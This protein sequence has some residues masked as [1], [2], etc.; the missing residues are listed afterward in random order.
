MSRPY[1]VARRP[2]QKNYERLRVALQLYSN[3]EYQKALKVC[4][5]IYKE[6]ATDTD[7]LILIGA[8]Y[9]QLYQLD[10]CEFYCGQCLSV[11]PMCAE[12]MNNLGA[13]YWN[14]FEYEKSRDCFEKAT[15]LKP[16]FALSYSNLGVAHAKLGFPDKALDSLSI[17]LTL[18][19]KCVDSL[20]NLGYFHLSN[21]NTND[22][23]KNYLKALQYDPTYAIP[24]SN[25]GS[26]Y[27]KQK[28]FEKS[29][30]SL[31]RALTFTKQRLSDASIN[32]SNCG[33]YISLPNAQIEE[34]IDLYRSEIR[35]SL[36]NPIA[37]GNFGIVSSLH[38]GH[39]S[40][41]RS[42]LRRSV[43]MKTT[44]SENFYN[45]GSFS[46]LHG[47]EDSNHCIKYLSRALTLGPVNSQVLNNL[48]Y[49]ILKEKNMSTEALLC[50]ANAVDLVKEGE[51]G[52]VSAEY[53]GIDA[54]NSNE[55]PN[56]EAMANLV[57]LCSE[58]NMYELVID[59]LKNFSLIISTPCF[60][61]NFGCGA[62][63]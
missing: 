26:A 10:L 6:D 50:F 30:T 46:L 20:T 29:R 34:A 37:C 39:I 33:L 49:A 23:I 9:L 52:F 17:S 13:C 40:V 58:L 32:L 18:D 51:I 56:S 31:T 61:L 16:R 4:R 7:N 63:N 55:L 5:Y 22:A 21:G 12:A 1:A 38:G 28:N 62:F 2:G 45:F 14:R 27:Y 25:L 8:T 60:S 48:G 41:S 47:T 53:F 42:L 35:S 3:G 11:D 54:S 19:E 36:Q 59:L 43:E 15:T 44:T 57:L 24:W